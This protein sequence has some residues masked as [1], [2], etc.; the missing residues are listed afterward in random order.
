MI[1]PERMSRKLHAMVRPDCT[2]RI[3]D[4]VEGMVKR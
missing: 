1:T 4:I 2:E 3:C